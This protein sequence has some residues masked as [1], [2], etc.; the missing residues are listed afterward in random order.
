M[1]TTTTQPTRPTDHHVEH[2]TTDGVGLQ[3]TPIDIK[4]R[5]SALWITTM[6]VYAYVDI[7]GLMRADFLE[8]LLD[9]EIVGTPLSVNQGFLIFAV[10]YILPASLMVYLSLT[11]TPKVNRRANIAVAGIY[12]VTVAAACVGEEWLYFLIG[13]AVELVLFAVIIRTAWRWPAAGGAH[14]RR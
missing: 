4:L 9:G 6:F 8:G 7:F 2:H 1:T 5:L 13:S 12:M 10:G 11:L 14:A 3:N